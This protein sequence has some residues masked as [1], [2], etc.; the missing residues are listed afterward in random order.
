MVVSH[1][2]VFSTPK[3]KQGVRTISLDPR[4]VATLR[5]WRKAQREEQLAW[6]PGYQQSGLVFTR[7][8]GS[9]VHPTSLANVFDRLV[10]S[11]GLPRLT[12]HGLRHTFAT[13]A[14]QAGEHPKKVQEVLGHSSISVTL[15]IYSHVVPSMAEETT[16]KV[17]AL[18]FGS[19]Q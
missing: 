1:A 6:G 7:E 14:L 8:D 4:T 9:P 15:N 17:A 16:G 3:T 12:V 18:I 11:S 10:R 19:G 5:A 2:L 13:L